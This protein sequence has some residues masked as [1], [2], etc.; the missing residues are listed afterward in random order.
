MGTLL[1]LEPPVPRLRR[2]LARRGVQVDGA[3][4]EAA[5]RAEIAYYRAHNME[6]ADHASL[7]GLRRR[8]AAAL[9][10][11]LGEAGSGAPPALVHEA[12][13]AALRFQAYPDAPPALAR[14]R[15]AGMRL[16]VVSNWDV[17]LHERLEDAGIASCVD[18][19][20]ASAELGVAKPDP[21][22]FAHALTMA[23]VPGA[24]AVH[25]GDSPVEDVAG[26]RAAGIE[27]VLLRRD[28]PPRRED[29]RLTIGSLA[30]LPALA[31]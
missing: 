25:V 18:G 20:I 4:A 5:M 9:Q 28:R 16:V 17:S 24:E 26:A 10:A 29:P 1:E 30:E 15:E 2:E 22:I 7:A 19:A 11:A 13:L 14:L 27:P 8:C 3:T 31:A 23:G 21:A 12:M 6:G